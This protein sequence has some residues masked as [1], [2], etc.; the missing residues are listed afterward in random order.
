V[1]WQPSSIWI[2]ASILFALYVEN[3]GSFGET[4][5]SLAGVVILLLWFY[6]S[7]F[8]VLL[9]A[10]LNAEIEDRDRGPHHRR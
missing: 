7:A 9:G 8:I 5:G 6:I 1:P 2:V 10:E 4:Y 3:F